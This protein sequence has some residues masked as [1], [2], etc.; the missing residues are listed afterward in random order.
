MNVV[1]ECGILSGHRAGVL[2]AG[3]PLQREE[4]G[5]CPWLEEEEVKAET[6]Y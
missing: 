5:I 2:P 4:Q 1:T 6:G 3:F